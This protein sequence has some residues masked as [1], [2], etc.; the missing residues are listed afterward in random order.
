MNFGWGEGVYGGVAKGEAGPF[1][2]A[3]YIVPHKN[4]K[5]EDCFMLPICLPSQVMKRF[6]EELAHILGNQN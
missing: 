5:G 2:G 6:A 3:T 1:P 4:A